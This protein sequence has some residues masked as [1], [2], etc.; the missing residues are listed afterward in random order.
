MNDD[1]FDAA[2]ELAQELL[3]STWPRMPFLDA[4]R[5]LVQD[6]DLD[7][8]D[9]EEIVDVASRLPYKKRS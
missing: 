4:E 9:A 1:D 6:L 5:I 3:C 8:D 2:V 7:P